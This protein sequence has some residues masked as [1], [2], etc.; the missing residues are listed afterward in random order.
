MT[1]AERRRVA[2]RRIA[3]DDPQLAARLILMTLPAAAARIPGTLAYVLDLDGIGSYR[4][5][6]S[7]GRARIDDGSRD[8]DD[9]DFRL[10]TDPRTLVDLV[11][12][13]SGPLGLMLSGRLRIRGKRRQALRLRAMSSADVGLDDVVAN[14]GRLDPDVM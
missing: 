6:V 3:A 2:L 8:G 12:G 14:G 13:A 1:A 9:V 10:T 7:A 5:S 11:T 4:V